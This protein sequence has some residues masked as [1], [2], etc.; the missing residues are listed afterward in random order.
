MSRIKQKVAEKII[1]NGMRYSK[2]FDMYIKLL[3]TMHKTLHEEFGEK[4]EE[5][6]IK[7]MRE[8]GT[9]L[10]G[11]MRTEL[12]YGDGIED[13]VSMWKVVCRLAKFKIEV[14]RLGNTIV[15]DHVHCPQWEKFRESG[16]I[17]CRRTCIPMVEA[18]SQALKP[19]VEVKV[20]REP[21]MNLPCVK[22]IVVNDDNE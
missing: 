19:N 2:T 4:G 3:E 8:I 13:L 17:L 11:D 18:M 7:C 15:F 20:L 6:F 1:P 10:A 16:D 14:K 5:A 22:G 12:G 21:D 9:E